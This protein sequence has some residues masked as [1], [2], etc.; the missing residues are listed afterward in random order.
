MLSKST[1][2]LILEIKETTK[3]IFRIK[4]KAFMNF[5]LSNKRQRITEHEIRFEKINVVQYF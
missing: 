5:R 3:V 4:R 1:L 2:K